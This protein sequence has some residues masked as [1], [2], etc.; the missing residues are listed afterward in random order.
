M[1]IFDK[2]KN[3]FA[4]QEGSVILSDPLLKALLN[5]EPITREKA[6]TLPAVSSAVDLISGM[7][8]SMPVKLYKISKGKVVEV[9]ND[10]RTSLLNGDTGDT[11]NGYQ[12]RKAMVEDYLLGK[13][14]YAYIERDNLLN[15][16]GLYYV[17]D[18]DISPM[19]NADP[20]FKSVYFLINAKTY[21]HWDI[22]K[23]LRDTKDGATGRGL[24]SEISKSL[25]TAYQTLM[26]QLGLVKKGGNKKGFLKS[27]VPL[28][29]KAMEKLKS[30]WAKMYANNEESVVVLNN[31]LEFQE[32]SNS[33]VEMQMNESK[34][35]LEDE[36]NAVF[37][38]HDDF[39]LTFKEAIFPIMKAFETECNSLLL[40]EN[41]K[42]RMFF[43]F[44]VKEI[45]RASIKERYEANGIA[46]RD[47]WM[48]VNEVRRYENK[49]EIEGM[50]VL[51]LGLGSAL[52]DTQ[53]QRFFVPNTGEVVDSGTEEV[54]E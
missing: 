38:I 35:T 20:I 30:A 48:T 21:R 26:Y 19:K 5:N 29:D 43:E 16:I 14:G 27:K 2:I 7:I 45:L 11:L 12:M 6:L 9:E 49:N 50:D 53:S 23:I 13:G 25:E 4:K 39:Y 32:S 1:N 15:P 47:G 10:I 31:G 22:L 8:A 42:R 44:D 17:K 18:I 46:I 41:E 52:Y 54:S 37:H 34:K 36:I 33:S 40:N 51:N 3:A 28:D 24:T